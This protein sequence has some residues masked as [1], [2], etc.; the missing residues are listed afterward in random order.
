[1]VKNGSARLV[2][3]GAASALCLVVAVI[4]LQDQ[5]WLKFAKDPLYVKW[6]Y[7]SIEVGCVLVAAALVLRPRGMT[8]LMA[9]LCGVGPLTGYVLSRGPG[10]PNYTDD[11]GNWGEPLGV[12]SLVVEG[13][14]AVLTLG[15]LAGDRLGSWADEQTRHIEQSLSGVRRPV[16]T[17]GEASQSLN[18]TASPSD[19]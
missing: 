2:C 10:L 17:R 6:G 9:F 11:R 7:I 12:V 3:A 1:M 16:P 14:L 18:L 13:L 8:F 5:E 19:G 15:Y 4:H